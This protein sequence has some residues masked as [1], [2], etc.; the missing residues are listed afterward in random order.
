MFESN[1]DTRNYQQPQFKKKGFSYDLIK[2]N[3][4]KKISE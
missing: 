4:E 2:Q 3:I 1:L